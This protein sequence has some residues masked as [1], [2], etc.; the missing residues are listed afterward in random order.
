[1]KVFG[2]S[3]DDFGTGAANFE[4]LLRMCPFSELKIDQSVVQRRAWSR[5]SHSFMKFC[6]HCCKTELGNRDR[7]GGD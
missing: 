2:V 3:I 6:V 7:G 4:K 5:A 1:M